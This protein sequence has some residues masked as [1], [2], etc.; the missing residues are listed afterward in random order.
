[1]PFADVVFV[2][3]LTWTTQPYAPEGMVLVAHHELLIEVP[4]ILVTIPGVGVRSG[5][6]ATS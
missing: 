2:R 5:S 3:G 1:M 6:N 4:M